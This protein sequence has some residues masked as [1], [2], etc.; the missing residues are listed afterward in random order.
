MNQTHWFIDGYISSYSLSHS[1]YCYFYHRKF[2]LPGI[3]LF[4]FNRKLLK[5]SYG[6]EPE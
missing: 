2:V 4:E 3:T 1:W 5:T 6:L